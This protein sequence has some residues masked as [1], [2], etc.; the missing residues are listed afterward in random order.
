VPGKD[1]I[2]S[3]LQAFSQGERAALDSLIPLVY[4]DLRRLAQ[5]QLGGGQN[6][7]ATSLVH[8]LYVKLSSNGHSGWENRRHFYN[9]AAAALRNLV[10]DAARRRARLAPLDTSPAE[11]AR[12]ADVEILALEAAMTRL[13]ERDVRLAR[14]VEC[15]FFAGLTVEETAHAIGVS[16]PTV[17]RGWQTAQAWLYKELHPSPREPV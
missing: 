11:P 14:I 5:R 4:D 13:A 17:K 16:T 3:L 7:S 10:Y 15:R 2:S 8:Q 12:H 9:F 1:E 6:S